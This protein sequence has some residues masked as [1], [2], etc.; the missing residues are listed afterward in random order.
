M[1]VFFFKN[2]DHVNQK[3]RNYDLLFALNLEKQQQQKK[4]T[5]KQQRQQQYTSLN[6]ASNGKHIPV[7]D[8]G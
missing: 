2:H 7:A 1:L 4:K 5:N 8:P 3:S 6:Q